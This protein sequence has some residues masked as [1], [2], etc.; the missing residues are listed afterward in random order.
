MFVH[1]VISD[2]D[3]E[4]D[5]MPENQ[6]KV[7]AAI[8]GLASTALAPRQFA[9]RSA[10]SAASEV[11]AGALKD[12][13][14]QRSQIDGLCVHIGSPRGTDYDVLANMLGINVRFCGQPW[15][16]GRF[17]ASVI[18]HAAMALS[19]GMAN[20]VLCVAAYRN[21]NEGGRH[22]TKAR[23]TFFEDLRQGGGPHAET[24]H[25][26]FTA[27]VAGTA[28]AYQRYL[29][30]YNISADKLAT[31]ALTQRRNA[32]RNPRAAMRKPLSAEEYFSSRFIVEPMHLFDCSVEV[33]GAV[34]IILTTPDRAKDCAKAPVHLLGFQGLNA[35]PNEFC[36]GQ[37]G[38]GFNQADVFDYV[39]PGADQMVYRMAGLKPSDVDVLEVYDAFA[40][41]SLWAIERMGHCKGGEAADW[42]QGGRIEIGGELPL[43]T[44]GGMLSEGHLNGWPQIAE[45]IRQLR[46]EAGD[47]QVAD[48]RIGQ[49]GTSIGDSLI[50]G[51]DGT[52]TAR[53]A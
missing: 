35:G 23:S 1:A 24:P 3:I 17:T 45:I 2:G 27:P 7:S 15:S 40:P 26:G 14:L 39:S 4:S 49:W 53:A 16:H 48:A 8:T 38:L 29:H 33:D 22:G 13:G 42:I 11:V 18:T 52:Q 36:M 25:A 9:N 28:M 46:G 12:A 34:A 31:L 20:Y 30:K 32:M 6:W 41:M 44:S 5:L 19:C 10:V 50:L 43:N 21:S 37:P 51:R 47:R